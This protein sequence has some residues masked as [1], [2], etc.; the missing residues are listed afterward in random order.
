MA[1]DR[2]FR[3]VNDYAGIHGFFAGLPAFH[4]ADYAE[5]GVCGMILLGD[6]EADWRDVQRVEPD[7]RER[8]SER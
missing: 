7:A 3:E 8:P 6:P 1:D 4:G 5:G 2:R